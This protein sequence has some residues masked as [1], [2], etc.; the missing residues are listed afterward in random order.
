[1]SFSQ[2][3]FTRRSSQVG[4]SVLAA[5]I[6]VAILTLVASAIQM[7]TPVV[8]QSQG[9]AV[10]AAGTAMPTTG[11]ATPVAQTSTSATQVTE[12]PCIIGNDIYV[13]EKKG[14]PPQVDYFLVCDASKT[15]L[16]KQPLQSSTFGTND[17]GRCT[18][19]PNGGVWGPT[20]NS[21]VPWVC[22]KVWCVLSTMPIVSASTGVGKSYAGK[23]QGGDEMCWNVADSEQ[24]QNANVA[25]I[26]TSGVT[27]A[28]NGITDEVER[29]GIVDLLNQSQGGVLDSGAFESAYS[30]PTKTELQ[31][32]YD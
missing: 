22:K 16:P 32:T 15:F 6:L 17:K 21:N 23:W 30:N 28:M 3:G 5:L 13:M 2:R 7:T 20:R 1:M 29:K 9:A 12:K 27:G 4:A 18:Q 26:R 24:G 25:A 19:L 31:D 8:S 10:T 11:A 14:Q